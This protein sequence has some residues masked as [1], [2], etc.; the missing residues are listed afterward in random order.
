MTIGN[1][2]ERIKIRFNNRVQF[3]NIRHVSEFSEEEIKNGWYDK[4]DFNRMSEEVSEI[5][6]LIEKGIGHALCIRG[7]EHIVEE[8]LANYRAEKMINSIDGKYRYQINVVEL[9]TTYAILPSRISLSRHTPGFT[10]HILRAAVLDEQEEQWD[11][12]V[13]DSKLIAEIYAEYTKP[14]EK[15]AHLIGLKDAE[16]GYK[17]FDME[18]VQ[19]EE[20]K[21]K[22]AKQKKGKKK[23]K[24]RSS[25]SSSSLPTLSSSSHSQLSSSLTS[26][27]LHNEMSIHSITEVDEG[28]KNTGYE[29]IKSDELSNVVQNQ[30]LRLQNK[31]HAKKGDN[32]NQ[33]RLPQRKGQ[34]RSRKS[35]LD[36]K[37]GGG[38]E[39]SPFVFS[40]DGTIQFRKPD[41]EKIKREQSLKRRTCIHDSLSKFLEDDDDEEDFLTSLLR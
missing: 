6:K 4:D 3:K 30:N 18:L 8:D 15:E 16:E 2:N 22:K 38:S 11:D 17:S 10:Y 23:E 36:R 41:I 20:E 14:L 13:E 21:I 40:R 32:K 12:G 19:P 5:A 1:V 24:S 25:S 35:F 27:S 37:Y 31:T 7:L 26:L 39:L 33:K 28:N 29:K 34:P 9:C